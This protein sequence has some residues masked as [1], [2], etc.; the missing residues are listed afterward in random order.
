[1]FKIVKKYMNKCKYCGNWYKNL[2]YSWNRRLTWK[3]LFIFVSV[4]TTLFLASIFWCS[5]WFYLFQGYLPHPSLPF[6]GVFISFL[7][8][9]Y[10]IYFTFVSFSLLS[11]IFVYSLS[12]IF[13]YAKTFRLSLCIVNSL[14][15]IYIYNIACYLLLS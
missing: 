13:V 10:F 4:I 14:F 12:I 15:N 7:L 2:T 3:Q 5:F 1:M 11:H 9:E 8:F 6:H